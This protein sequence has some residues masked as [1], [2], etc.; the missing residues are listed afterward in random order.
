MWLFII[1]L[2]I[3]VAGIGLIMHAK[4]H[5]AKRQ[6]YEPDNKWSDCENKVGYL[7]YGLCILDVLMAL[8]I[9]V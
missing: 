2:I 1:E 6:K 5:F 4:L 8:F 7:G 9:K 3:L